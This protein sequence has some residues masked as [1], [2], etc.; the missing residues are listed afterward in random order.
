MEIII[1]N[2]YS[3]QTPVGGLGVSSIKKGDEIKVLDFEKEIFR[4]AKI[5]KIVKKKLNGNIRLNPPYDEIILNEKNNVIS[6][7]NVI[8][9]AKDCKKGILVSPL[10]YLIPEYIEDHKPDVFYIITIDEDNVFAKV[11]IPNKYLGFFIQ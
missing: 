3:I 10:T 1:H 8:C 11:S 7:N 2:S 6:R 4:V 9:N 5:K